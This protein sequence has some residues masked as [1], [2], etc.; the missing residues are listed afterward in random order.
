LRNPF[1][2]YLLCCEL[3]LAKELKGES[4]LN[5]VK[6]EIYKLA[7]KKVRMVAGDW[8]KVLVTG[9]AGFMGSWLVDELIKRGYEVVSIDNLSGGFLRNVSKSCKFIE[10]DIKRF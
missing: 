7:M 3:K 1:V 4:G 2:T 8:M 10:M 9:G 5:M 6:P